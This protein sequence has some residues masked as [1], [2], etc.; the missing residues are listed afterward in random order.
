MLQQTV[1]APVP[2]ALI[3]SAECQCNNT[4]CYF[5]NRNDAGHAATG[6]GGGLGGSEGGE[7]AL[8]MWGCR[9]SRAHR[10][11]NALRSCTRRVSVIMHWTDYERGMFLVLKGGKK[12]L[13]LFDLAAIVPY[14]KHD[15]K[16]D[17]QSKPKQ[18]LLEEPRIRE[19]QHPALQTERTLTWQIAIWAELTALRMRMS[20]EGAEQI[21]LHTYHTIK[22]TVRKNKHDLLL[23][24]SEQ[25]VKPPFTFC[26]IAYIIYLSSLGLWT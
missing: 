10:E 16:P 7:R 18:I 8:T 3:L 1:C 21:P 9:M 4:T 13:F 2:P 19:A 14:L 24:D 23:A 15:I 22:Y 20:W 5:P 12:T 11:A 17:C 26:M 25:R 6:G